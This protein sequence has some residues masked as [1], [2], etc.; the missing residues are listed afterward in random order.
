MTEV[1][2]TDGTFNVTGCTNRHFAC[3]DDELNLILPK[4]ALSLY[5]FTAF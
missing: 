5:F 3:N 4:F 1:V 2:S